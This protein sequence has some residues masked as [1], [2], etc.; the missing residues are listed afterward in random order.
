MQAQEDDATSAAGLPQV[1]KVRGTAAKGEG[2]NQANALSQ[3]KPAIHMWRSK[4]SCPGRESITV[5][6]PIKAPSGLSRASPRSTDPGYIHASSATAVQGF[7]PSG[8][9]SFAAYRNPLKTFLI[10]SSFSLGQLLSAISETKVTTF[11]IVKKT[12]KPSGL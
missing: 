1:V 3:P 11:R 10:Y 7:D 2:E 5:S 8:L 6:E 9:Q 12:I 4:P